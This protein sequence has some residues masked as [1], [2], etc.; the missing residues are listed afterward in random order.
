MGAVRGLHADGRVRQRL[1]AMSTLEHVD[2]PEEFRFRATVPDGRW[3]IS[4]SVEGAPVDLFDPKDGGV[5]HLIGMNRG[6]YKS[7][8]A[9][10]IEV[11]DVTGYQGSQGP[12]Y[13]VPFDGSSPR[14]LADDITWDSFRLDDG[15][16]VS[17][18]DIGGG[19]LGEFVLLDTGDRTAT[20]IDDRVDAS[21]GVSSSPEFGADA[22]VYS[23]NDGDRS[24]IWVA[25]IPER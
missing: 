12:L 19:A 3:L 1:Y 20:S 25:R 21:W 18:I 8:L 2:L 11:L 13:F 7:I 6:R 4:T 17:I 14:T 9:D 22:F 23:V 5:R 16:H 10:G 15:R 24:G